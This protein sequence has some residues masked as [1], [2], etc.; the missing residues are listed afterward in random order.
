MT[1]RLTERVITLRRRVFFDLEFTGLTQDADPVS[2]GMVSED[3]TGFYA[4][5]SDYDRAKVTPWVKE[6]VLSR[7]LFG[8]A[9]GGGPRVEAGPRDFVARKALAFLES[10]A[11]GACRV[12]L[13]G[14]CP[15]YDWV[16]F[17]GLFGGALNLPACVHPYPM[18][19]ATYLRLMGLDPDASREELA[20][21][22]PSQ[23]KNKHNAFHDAAILR[24]CVLRLDRDLMD[25]STELGRK[26]VL[27][28]AC[29]DAVKIL[30]SVCP[31]EA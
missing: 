3:G 18:D 6:N 10:Q 4:E 2:L 9:R 5:F 31:K 25:L 27:E 29:R 22:N 20:V 14:D 17:C 24:A 21:A 13:W 28:R 19:L 30:E 8:A 16:L 26:R 12:E 1:E 11:T 15:S 23:N 7:L